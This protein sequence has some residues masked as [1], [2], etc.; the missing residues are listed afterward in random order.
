[1]YFGKDYLY[2]VYS[3]KKITG[4]IIKYTLLTHTNWG[5]QAETKLATILGT[6]F[7]SLVLLGGTVIQNPRRSCR[8]VPKFCMGS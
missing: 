1:M 3:L 7:F 5:V 6:F 2:T 4:E 8:R